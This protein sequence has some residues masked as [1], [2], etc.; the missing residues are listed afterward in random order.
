MSHLDGITLYERILVTCT[1]VASTDTGEPAVSCG[2]TQL[3]LTAC[4]SI[5]SE[6]RMPEGCDSVGHCPL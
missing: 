1:E 5:P 3:L 2:Y 4:R 6:Q